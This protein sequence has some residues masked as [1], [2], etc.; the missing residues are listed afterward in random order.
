MLWC[1][2]AVRSD[3][4]SEVDIRYDSDFETRWDKTQI[5]SLSWRLAPR[6]LA[7][8]CLSR[9]RFAHVAR[10]RPGC[11]HVRHFAMRL[12]NSQPAQ[13]LAIVSAQVAW[14]YLGRER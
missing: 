3:T 11:R 10:R 14:R 1:I 7:H 4:D 8:R 6:N 12:T 2:F 5:R 13:D 9:Q